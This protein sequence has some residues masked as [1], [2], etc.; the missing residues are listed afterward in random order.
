MDKD[1]VYSVVN[2]WRE[3]KVI[4]NQPADKEVL[5]PMSVDAAKSRIPNSEGRSIVESSYAYADAGEGIYVLSHKIELDN[6]CEYL[7]DTR[8][9]KVLS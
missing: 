3:A 9:G 8:T 6:G 7:I 4:E 5:G 1:G 2:K